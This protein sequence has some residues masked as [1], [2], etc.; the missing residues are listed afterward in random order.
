MLSVAPASVKEEVSEPLAINL[1]LGDIADSIINGYWNVHDFVPSIDHLYEGLIDFVGRFSSIISIITPNGVA[2][3]PREASKCLLDYTR[4]VRFW[5]GM[6][7]AITDLQKS[8]PDE[9]I[10]VLY[11]GS[12]PFATLILPLLKIFNSDEISIT[13]LDLFPENLSRVKGII[14]TLKAEDYIKEYICEDATQY[15]PN[16]GSHLIV[17]ETMDN[18]LLNEPYAHIARHLSEYLKD[19]GVFIPEK[20]VVDIV[21]ISNNTR[22][23]LGT[24]AVIA[25]VSGELP[26]SASCTFDSSCL[27]KD[28]TVYLETRLEIY[29]AIPL[30]SDQSLITRPV[31]L[32]QLTSR[33]NRLTVSYSLGNTGATLHLIPKD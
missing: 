8:F 15:I 28:R 14:E 12:G 3:S 1:F 16:E 10:N 20:V 29:N 6:Y 33:A 25:P 4:T 9:K 26:F 22:K 23:N 19:G 30:M 31:Q 27:P 11:A 13:I 21:A 7:L 2:L 24:V 17:S 5:Q 18:G 32:P